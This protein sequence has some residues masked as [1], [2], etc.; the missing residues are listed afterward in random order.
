[1]VSSDELVES[2]LVDEME[3]SSSSWSIDGTVAMLLSLE[4]E[5]E[6]EES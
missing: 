1:M 3:E 6:V 4:E 5:E 2:L